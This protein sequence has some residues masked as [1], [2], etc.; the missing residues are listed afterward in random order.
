M[1]SN[2]GR[3][4]KVRAFQDAAS[5]GEAVVQELRRQLAQPHAGPTALMLAGGSTPMAAYRQLAADAPP[6]PPWLHF[7][8]SD[9][10]LVPP[11]DPKSNFGN[12]RALFDALHCAHEKVI[13]VHGEKQLPEAV[14]QFDRDIGAFLHAG[15]QIPFG[16]LG[17]GAD[18]HTA[19]LFTEKHLQEAAGRFAIGVSRPDG[20]NGISVTP[21]VLRRVGRIVFLV[22]G[23]D[24]RPM[25]ERLLRSPQTVIAGRAVA[26]APIVEIWCDWAANPL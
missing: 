3:M 24:K 8:Y 10:R 20:L 26:D 16:L 25:L 17:M 4:F 2:C 23:A 19:S 11:D 18:G 6:A 5:L 13:R 14:S 22:A 15:G 21:D 1:G 9:D 12:T 7:L